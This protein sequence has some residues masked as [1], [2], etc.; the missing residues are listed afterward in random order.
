MLYEDEEVGDED[1][2]EDIVAE[3]TVRPLEPEEPYSLEQ[4]LL[5]GSDMFQASSFLV[6]LDEAMS[7]CYIQFENIKDMLRDP[8]HEDVCLLPHMEHLI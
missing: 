2:M 4:D 1:L 6:T 5:L 8:V 7:Q 3:T